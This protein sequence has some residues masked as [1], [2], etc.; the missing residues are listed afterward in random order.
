MIRKR[1]EDIWYKSKIQKL[2][3]LADEKEETLAEAYVIVGNLLI[4]TGLFDHPNSQKLLDMLAEQKV[5]H[6][7]LL[8]WDTAKMLEE[9]KST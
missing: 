6:K 8:P 7:D 9:V 4:E 3:K 5:I 2:E 1:K